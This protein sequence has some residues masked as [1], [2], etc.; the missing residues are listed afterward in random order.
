MN[1]EIILLTNGN[2]HDHEQLLQGKKKNL[3]DE[4]IAYINE[5]FNKG[6][7]KYDQI[8]NFIDDERLKHNSFEGEKNPGYRQIEYRL[9][10]YRNAEVKPVIN[11]GDIM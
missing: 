11:L 4:M 10:K 3:S 1:N 8:I 7:T 2:E 5:L 9:T 6:I